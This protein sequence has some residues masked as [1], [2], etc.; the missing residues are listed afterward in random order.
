LALNAVLHTKQQNGASREI[1]L[2]EFY[3]LPGDTPYRETVLEKGELITGVFIPEDSVCRQSH[4]L[5]VR[6]RS[7]YEFALA[8]AAVAVEIQQDR[9]VKARV[10]LGGVGTIP[11]RAAEAENALVNQ[12]AGRQT[13]VT[14]ADAA[15]AEAKPL[16][17][18]AFKVELAKRTLVLALEELVGNA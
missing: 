8:S 2:Q 16:R 3:L 17:H 15:L 1:P 9:I 4:Y 10:A 18:N 12:P 14:A 5:K 7:S 13:F 11:W 6:D